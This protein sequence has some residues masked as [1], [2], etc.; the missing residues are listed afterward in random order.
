MER[1]K[2]TYMRKDRNTLTV[3]ESAWNPLPS[4]SVPVLR[5]PVSRRSAN[6][7]LNCTDELFDLRWL[8]EE[9]VNTCFLKFFSDIVVEI[10][11]DHQYRGDDLVPIEE[12]GDFHAV[13]TRNSEVQSDQV[14]A[15][16]KGIG[17]G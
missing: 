7:L 9:V 13:D 15:P 12:T 16:R 1:G 10:S 14:E 2:F 3:V 4:L 8:L 11:G 6:G 5:F 17:N